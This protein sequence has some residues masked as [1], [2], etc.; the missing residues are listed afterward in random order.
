MQEV[1][2]NVYRIIEKIG[3]GGGGIVYKAHHEN[4]Q[5]YVVLKQI[6][7]KLSTA[8]ARIEVDLL[9]N[10]KHTYLPQVLDFIEHD[11]KTFTVMDFIDGEDLK[12]YTN[13]KPMKTKE[14]IH[15]GVEL[16]E[17]VKYLHSQTPSVIHSDI[18][19][20]NI[21]ITKDG[22]I[23]LIDFNISL[24]FS[25]NKTAI[26]GTRG[27]AAPEQL[28][29]AK[30]AYSKKTEFTNGSDKTELVSDKT[31]LVSDETEL[32]SDETE[33]VSDEAELVSDEAELIASQGTQN[34]KG[35]MFGTISKRSDIY[36][37]GA[38]LY[39]MITGERPSADYSR[40]KP[41]RSFKV[42]VPEGLLIITEKA[43][44]LNPSKRYSS[45]DAMLTAL[46]NVM[47]LDRRYR[48]LSV[49]RALVSVLC[50]LGLM[51]SALTMNYGRS[52]VLQERSDKY[53]GMINAADDSITEGDLEN[54]QTVI[55]EAR[56]FMPAM[57][58]A[59]Y[60]ELRLKY[61][62]GEYTQCVEYYLNNPV[63]TNSTYDLKENMYFVAG[64]AYFEL[65]DYGKAIEVYTRCLS[66]NPIFTDCYRDLAI[67]Y[68]RMGLEDE[69]VEILD[70]AI[71]A[72]ASNDQIYLVQGE[73]EITRCNYENAIKY[74]E[75]AAKETTNE[76]LLYRTIYVYARLC[77]A[78]SKNIKD[79]HKRSSAF[80]EKYYTDDNSQY[81]SFICEILASQYSRL[82][83]QTNDEAM[84]RKSTYYYEKLIYNASQKYI[85][86]KNCFEIY[87]HLRDYDDCIRILSKMEE[88]FPNDY[89]VMMNYA[90]VHID[91]QNDIN[92]NQRSYE[93]TLL[94]Y[95]K[96]VE[97]YEEYRKNGKTDPNMDVL[98]SYID[99]L[100]NNGWIA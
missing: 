99:Q 37:I 8:N 50:V 32:V 79:A 10:L 6:K 35:N 56:D 41:V 83:M 77:D 27:F 68:A 58:E 38:V 87:Y 46:Q 48:V 17:A 92:I 1:I 30:A 70:K 81:S 89:W 28:S 73:I 44:A 16:C 84:F 9:K 100:R 7:G 14:I 72:K 3:Q 88:A 19:P 11:G 40:I 42:K 74:L 65:E 80:I 26:G 29:V 54:A 47:K 2:N 97:Y 49:S 57:P 12:K 13:D 45:V 60:E 18:K 78:Q 4:L 66:V 55:N 59:Y 96:A 85:V 75:M 90:I 25:D 69:A 86:Y 39:Y 33:L 64:N 36:S 53:Y 67:S 71:E 34:N 5:K 98:K 31:E 15:Y 20:E 94:Y 43:M 61:E 82:A 62:Q 91:I 51:A 93:N 24:M 52:T 21:M 76:Y 23:C 63:L 22:N 95:E